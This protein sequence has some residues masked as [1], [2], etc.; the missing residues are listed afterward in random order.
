M[1]SRLH[2]PAMTV[3]LLFSLASSSLFANVRDIELTPDQEAMLEQIDVELAVTA[4]TLA[5]NLQSWRQDIEAVQREIQKIE[6]AADSPVEVD[7]QAVQRLATIADSLVELDKVVSRRLGSD[8]TLLEM[9][10]Q[11]EAA[12]DLQALVRSVQQHERNIIN[13]KNEFEAEVAPYVRAVEDLIRQIELYLELIDQLRDPARLT[14]EFLEDEIEARYFDKPYEVGDVKFTIK[15]DDFRRDRSLF[16]ENANI[17]VLIQY[18]G[19]DVEVMAT[20]IYFKYQ[21]GQLPTPKFD[22]MNV[23]ESALA[24]LTNYGKKLL[25]D[26]LKGFDLPV[27]ISE[28]Q[29]LKPEETNGHGCGLKFRVD[30]Q[31]LEMSSDFKASC[32][33]VEIFSDGRIDLKGF[34]ITLEKLKITCGWITFDGFGGE[35]TKTDGD[36]FVVPNAIDFDGNP[37]TIQ[38]DWVAEAETWVCFSALPK[39]EFCLNVKVYHSLPPDPTSGITMVGDIEILQQPIA[40]IVA[41]LTKDEISGRIDFPVPEDKLNLKA[42][43]ELHSRFKIDSNGLTSK[44]MFK[45]LSAVEAQCDMV[46]NFDGSGHIYATQQT[47]IGGAFNVDASLFIQVK[48]AFQDFHFEANFDA[49]VDLKMVKTNASFYVLASTETKPGVVVQWSAMGC[50]GEFVADSLNDV[51]PQYIA[52]ELEKDLPNMLDNVRKATVKWEREKRELAQKWVLHW[53]QTL[54]DQ[55]AKAGLV[56]GSTGD[57]RLDNMLA[58]ATSRLEKLRSQSPVPLPPGI[59]PDMFFGDG[60]KKKEKRPDPEKQKQEQLRQDF[61]T[62]VQQ[63]VA[64]INQTRIDRTPPADVRTTEDHHTRRLNRE[65]HVVFEQCVSGS[66][67]DGHGAIGLIV[68]CSGFQVQ[69]NSRSGQSDRDRGSAV[70]TATI[71]LENLVGESADR[72]TAKIEVEVFHDSSGMDAPTLVRHKLQEL[73]ERHLPE[74]ELG[75]RRKIYEKQLAIENPTDEPLAVWVIAEHGR[76]G[77]VSPKWVWQPNLPGTADGHR[78]VIPAHT[79]SPVTLRYEQSD[80]RPPREG[81]LKARRVRI[82]AESECGLTWPAYRSQDLWLVEEN[83]SL[84]GERAYDAEETQTRVYRFEP[85]RGSRVFTERLLKFRNETAEPLSIKYRLRINV[86]GVPTWKTMR[87][88]TLAPGQ[89]LAPTS[90]DGLRLRASQLQVSAAGTDLRFDKDNQ[91]PLWL[92]QERNGARVYRAGKMGDFVYAFQLGDQ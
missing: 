50:N 88:I 69:I 90:D 75:G 33:G 6:Q 24:S 91:Q 53:D 30:I 29:F 77:A 51:T 41:K 52:Q 34:G 13:Q 37:H 22:K 74:V 5:Q 27:T 38:A 9:L 23:E 45:L 79:T 14:R 70:V 61:D 55:A 92:V 85:K 17:A 26:S 12:Q 4:I 28:I 47:K 78:F 16:S 19:F 40:R 42:L 68:R 89:S 83:P 20:G 8:T 59:D 62:K 48:K 76:K 72:P 58:E 10:G 31:F 63:L 35:I 46:L 71:S 81:P 15:R 56:P 54:R 3:V 43:M 86:D 57:P 73:L 65:L 49:E 36:E 18:Q 1:F 80:A 7:M 44:G 82:W 21:K 60:K 66:S 87:Q 25:G 32:P 67:G 2:L 64:A 39:E 84:L 11:T